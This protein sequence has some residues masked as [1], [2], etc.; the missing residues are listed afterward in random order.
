MAVVTNYEN[1]VARSSTGEIRVADI[2]EPLLSMR[3]P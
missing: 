2:Q 3:R 1:V